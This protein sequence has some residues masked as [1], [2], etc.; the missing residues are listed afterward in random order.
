[1]SLL[2]IDANGLASQPIGRDLGPD[3]RGRSRIISLSIGI[4]R[5]ANPSLNLTG[6]TTD[7]ETIAQS[8]KGLAGSEAAAEPLTLLNENATQSGILSAFER[9]VSEA[10]VGDTLVVSYA[11]HGVRDSDGTFYLSTHGTRLDDLAG[12]AIA[13][14]QI[15]AILQ[16]SKA[17]VVLLLDACQSGA[18]GSNFFASNDQAASELL[19]GVPANIVIFS[20][21]KG[22]EFSFEAPGGKG[23]VFSR[24]FA[25]VITEERT[26]HDLNK[27]GA[28]E[29]SELFI[30]VK[31]K[32]LVDGRPV[33]EQYARVKG[34][35]TPV[36][37][38]PWIARN[39]MVGDFALF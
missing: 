8:L 24:A 10:R 18:A 5:Y 4:D 23:G 14:R 36:T 20:A 6:A 7:A 9:V 35:D 37:Q 12:T 27:N 28:I 38:T 2:A 17:R 31:R 32:V 15:G 33:R 16:R 11:G 13:W 22:R 1:M 3:P 39:Q 19:A 29:I 21:S 25:E 26:A 30:G 34:V